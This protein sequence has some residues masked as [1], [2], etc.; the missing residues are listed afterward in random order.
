MTSDRI[1]LE[2]TE[3]GGTLQMDLKGV[4]LFKIFRRL[5]KL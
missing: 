4:S 1:A 2:L 5:A 3:N